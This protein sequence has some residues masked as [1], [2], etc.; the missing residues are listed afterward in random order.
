[1][2]KDELIQIEL[3]LGTADPVV[4]ANQPLL[5]VADSAIGEGHDGLRTLAQFGS[6]GLRAPDMLETFF[7]QAG[8]G[9]KAI[10]EDRGTG[11]N[12]L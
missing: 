6:Q 9:L 10:A 5:E 7:V 12:V 1:V 2:T 11:S 3:Q 8:E 4:S